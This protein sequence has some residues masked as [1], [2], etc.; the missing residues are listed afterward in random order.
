M[1]LATDFAFFRN[2]RTFIKTVK[3][4]QVLFYSTKIF[5]STKNSHRV[6]PT[7]YF[8]ALQKFRHLFPGEYIQSCAGNLAPQYVHFNVTLQS[9]N[10]LV[11]FWVSSV[12]SRKI[13]LK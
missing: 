7:F 9:C 12:H 4:L 2:F 10:N 11:I 13:D 5:I 8:H 3:A 6:M 1:K